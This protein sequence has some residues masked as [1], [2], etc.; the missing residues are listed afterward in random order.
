MALY[1]RKQFYEKCGV[2]RGYLNMYIKRNKVILTNGMIDDTL[3][4]N[5]YFMQKCIDK[6]GIKPDVDEVRKPIKPISEKIIEETKEAQNE[7]DD[8][9][10]INQYSL[11]LEKKKLD[12][13]KVEEEI[14][15]TRIKREKMS[16]DLIPTDLVKVLFAS[17]FKSVT[18]SFH[19][20]IENL[21]STIAKRNS[22]DRGQVAKIRG[23]LTKV[24]NDAVSN[25]IE[26]SKKELKNIVDEYS[27]KRG[28]GE[29]E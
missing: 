27:Q 25:S 14:L 20:A 10:A 17:H 11:G 12:I 8:P 9:E 23:E 22:L 19:Q 18:T 2:A 21:I 1:T 5:A 13:E 15:I 24:I 4:E 16:G 6:R 29:K 3:Q 28:R 7:T 26:I